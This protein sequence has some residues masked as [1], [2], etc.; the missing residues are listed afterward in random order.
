MLDVV[1]FKHDRTDVV[2]DQYMIKKHS[3]DSCQDE[4][5]IYH[6]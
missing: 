2:L 4:L 3:L 6:T 5:K 1:G